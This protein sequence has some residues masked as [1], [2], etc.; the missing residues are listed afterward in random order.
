MPSMSLTHVP[1]AIEAHQVAGFSAASLCRVADAG[2]PGSVS[3]MTTANF[4]ELMSLINGTSTQYLKNSAGL[5]VASGGN[6]GIGTATPGSALDV[7]GAIRVDGSTS[8]YA[9]FQAPASMTTSVVWTLPSADGSNGQVLS[10]NGAGIL[11][12]VNQASGGISAL[13]G[14]VS[15][16]GTG[17][18]AATVASVGG[19]SA[20]NVHA[21][22]LLANAA[23]SA[24]TASTIVKRDASGNFTAGAITA[25][26]LTASSGVLFKDS[27]ANTITLQAPTTATGSYALKL[28]TSAGTSGY[29]LSTD[30]TGNLSWI[31]PSSGSVTSVGLT[32]PASL[33]SVSGSPVSASGTLGIS[34]VSQTANTVFAGPSS[35]LAAAPSFRNLTVADIQSSGG[36]AF[37]TGSACSSGQ[38]LQYN[39][40]ADTISCQSL[41]ISLTSG[42]SGTLPVANGG[43]GSTTGS[44]TGSGALTFTAGGANQNITLSPSGTGSTILGGN[45]GIGTTI[46]I[47]KLHTT[48]N[49]LIGAGADYPHKIMMAGSGAGTEY[50]VFEA[51]DASHLTINSGGWPYV[52]VPNGN[53]GVGTNTPSSPLHVNGSVASNSVILSSFSSSTT[54]LNNDNGGL[55]LYNTDS[56]TNNYSTIW[57]TTNDTGGT[58]QWP[59]SIQS[60]Y[61]SHSVGAATADLTFRTGVG[62]ITTERMRIDSSGN[63]GIGTTAP[64]AKLQVSAAPTATANYPMMALGDGAFD[65]TTAGFFAGSASGTYLGVNAASGYS[66]NLIDM[67]VAGVSK[68]KVSSA[69]VMTGDGSGITNLSSSAV[70]A[71]VKIRSIGYVFDGAGAILQAPRTS[72]YTVPFACTISA[73]NITVDAGTATVDVWKVASGTAIPTAANKITGSATPAISTGTAIHSTTLTG[74]TTSVSANDVF[75][76]NLSAVT[77][78]T[79]VSIVLE[80][81]Q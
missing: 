36:G 15:A 38:A 77:S 5:T 51:T 48:G 59:A 18:V 69:G 41:S 45:V 68:F 67:Q 80:C 46:P 49:F 30:G 73:W 55:E 14:D 44:I 54:S 12:W 61:T 57:F 23:T 75:G 13:T 3:P 42:V 19:S 65:G 66:G 70:P 34:L 24:N 17:S 81:D 28:P 29:V 79:N 6:V 60:I 8:G 21:A 47:E 40:I 74:W 35:G 37:L 78:A 25:T 20:A 22:E 7:N 11:S 10:T 58:K 50:S 26:S 9:G 33:L 4:T 1:Y 27:G 56:T 76:F 31:S 53:L 71:N 72:Y 43:T 39:S 63:V 52:V 16:S 64:V 62:T 32:V 2:V